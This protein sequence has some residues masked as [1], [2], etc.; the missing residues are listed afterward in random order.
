MD[1]K[2]KHRFKSMFKVITLAIVI[3]FIIF[4]IIIP[5]YKKKT[6]P[7][8]IK[9]FTKKQALEDYDYMWE[10]LEDNFP[11]FG[12]AN[13]MYGVDEDVVKNRYREMIETRPNLDF[14]GFNRIVSNCLREFKGI[15]HLNV[16][17]PDFY[18]WADDTVDSIEENSD[19]F[20]IF[21][22]MEDTIKSDR[23]INT[24]NYLGKD[25]PIH[26]ILSNLS[27]NPIKNIK[28]RKIND[29]TAY[30]QIKSMSPDALEKDKK[31]IF[32]F[33]KELSEERY[34]NLII[35]IRPYT[36]GSDYYWIQ[37]I[38]APNITDPLTYDII[39]F[40][41]GGEDSVRYFS[42]LGAEIQ[43]DMSKAEKYSNRNLNDFKKLHSWFEDFLIVEPLGEEKLFNGNIYY[44]T[45]EKIFSSSEAMAQF[46]KQTGF[47]TLVGTNTGGDGHGA[48]GTPLV[49]NL[50]NS[51]IIFW[52]R[53]GYAINDDGSSN[54][55]F[56]TSPDYY[57]EEGEDPLDACLRIIEELSLD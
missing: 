27:F 47:A 21:K 15:G 24:Y 14:D 46:C 9:N 39:T 20:G 38:V 37:N 29:K 33:Y 1:K 3:Y 51:G 5:T 40:L 6:A 7:D 26:K 30:I 41:V 23:S 22:R 36:S 18:Y 54:I 8:H 43:W 4:N 35:D 52:Y 17:T 48:G 10:I 25:S 28:K 57:A 42:D 53:V 45:D 50:P 55:E 44:L 32:D 34:E 16:F 31:V 11:Y 12:V 13:R 2:K 56:G 19:E 49:K